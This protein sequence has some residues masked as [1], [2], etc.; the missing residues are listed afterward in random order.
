MYEY[1]H[2]GELIKIVN[3]ELKSEDHEPSFIPE[4]YIRVLDR[5]HVI[6]VARRPRSRVSDRTPEACWRDVALG[7][8]LLCL[9]PVRADSPY[10]R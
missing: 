4:L 5:P 2:N 1:N 3:E 6:V 9:P 7:Q 10:V 8:C